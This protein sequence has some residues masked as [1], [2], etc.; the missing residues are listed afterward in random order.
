MCVKTSQIAIEEGEKES[1]SSYQ[2][3]G[4]SRPRAFLALRE[5]SRGYAY[6]TSLKDFGPQ[7]PME[8]SGLMIRTRKS[9]ESIGNQK[10]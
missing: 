5:N 8:T 3:Y 4:S 9:M 7:A 6:Q 2:I 10:P 1:W